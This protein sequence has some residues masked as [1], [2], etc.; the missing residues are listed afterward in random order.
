MANE[1]K[2]LEELE[3]YMDQFQNVRIRGDELISSSPF[4]ED[5]SPSFSLNLETGLW[6]DFGSVDDLWGKGNF[7]K[8]MAFLSGEHYEDVLERYQQY[9]ISRLSDIDKFELNIKLDLPEEYRTFDL[10]NFDY[11]RYK[12]DY[13]NNRGITDKAQSA[14]RIGYDHGNKAIAIPYH[15]IDGKVINIKFRKVS[16][17]QFYY[18][19][20]GQAI[21]NHVYGLHMIKRAKATKA[22]VVESEID[23]LYLWGYGI[24]AVAM[25]SANMSKRQEE[26]LDLSP[27][28]D[29]VLAFDNDPAG[30]RVTR[31]AQNRLSGKYGLQKLQFPQNCKDVNDIPKNKIK[32]QELSLIDLSLLVTL[33]S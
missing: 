33:S 24:P 29:L 7:I 6:I 15:D 11:W 22:F 12:S 20:D 3:P 23:C 21:G 19:P 14:F 9:H 32:S 2:Y 10:N 25:G 26:L 27:L 18:L 28:T 16:R 17:K 31:N 1:I 8:L 4:R 5:T 13:L 30:R